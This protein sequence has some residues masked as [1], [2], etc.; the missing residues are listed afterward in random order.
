M[1]ILKY[2]DPIF[3][4]GRTVLNCCVDQSQYCDSRSRDYF[5][6]YSAEPKLKWLQGTRTD[7]GHKG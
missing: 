4:L 2:L 7:E 1:E 6:V 5:G 3:Y